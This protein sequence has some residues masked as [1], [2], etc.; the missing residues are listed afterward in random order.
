MVHRRDDDAELE[1]HLLPEAGNAIDDR[2]A[3]LRVDGVDELVTDLERQHVEG[4]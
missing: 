1:R 3:H 4:Q 2:A